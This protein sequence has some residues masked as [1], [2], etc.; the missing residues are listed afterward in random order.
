ML[1]TPP[2]TPAPR[3]RPVLIASAIVGVI[4]AAV[5]LVVVFGDLPTGADVAIVSAAQTLVPIVVGLVTQRKVTPV[6][7]PVD[8]LGRPLKAYDG[9]AT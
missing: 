7:D 4:E 9:T 3:P 5:G 2:R 1:V 6:S 8:D